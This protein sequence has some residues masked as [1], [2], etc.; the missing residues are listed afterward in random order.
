M[1]NGICAVDGC[2]KKAH[3]RG[4]CQAHYRKWWR[5]GDPLGGGNAFTDPEEAFAARTEWRGECLLWTSGR[6]S[7]G[8]GRLRVNGVD[9]LAHRYAWEREH[10]PIPE[11]AVIDHTCFNPACCNVA[12]LR[13]ATQRQNCQ[14]LS[15]TAGSNTGHRNVYR[16]RSGK[17]Y[18][19]IAGKHVGSY[20]TLQEARTVAEGA[21]RAAFG[22]YAGCD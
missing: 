8:Y 16:H 3:S 1:G 5:Y 21:R 4:W 12:H 2:V 6:R 17:F 14:H 9:V 15:R 19:A 13:V 7:A 22:E 10:G 18:V 11:G 20:D